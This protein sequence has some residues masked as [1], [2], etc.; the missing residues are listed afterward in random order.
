M[1]FMTKIIRFGAHEAQAYIHNP[2]D[3]IQ[4]FWNKTVFY[5]AGHRGML[6][7]AYRHEPKGGLFV[8]IGAHRGNHSIFFAKVMGCQVFAF[9][10][11][12]DNLS[13]LT[14]NFAINKIPLSQLSGYALGAEVCEARL[15]RESESNSG[16]NHISQEGEVVDMVTLDAYAFK[17]SG[18]TTMK[19]DV[20]GYA[21]Q[22]LK[23]GAKVLTEGT[24][25]VY[26]EIDKPGE[27]EVIDALMEA[28][29]YQR[30]KGLVF[31]ATPTYLYKKQLAR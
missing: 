30:A 13:A 26:I 3:H 19:I 22:V 9:E 1:H 10:P 11:Q 25:N 6:S 8:D 23:G 31:N 7:Y 2:S 20:E 14:D 5:E 16:M 27:L 18:Y 12:H 24:G 4:G 15:M 21:E 28:Y 29:G 17:V